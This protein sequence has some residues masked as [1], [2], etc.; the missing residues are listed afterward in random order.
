MFV[1]VYLPACAW[2]VSFGGELSSYV[3]WKIG[4]KLFLPQKISYSSKHKEMLKT[5]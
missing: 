3:L 4:G 2:R 1:L 5:N